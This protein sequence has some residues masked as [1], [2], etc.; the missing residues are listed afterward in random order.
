MALAIK[1]L[2][3]EVYAVRLP[4]ILLTVLFLWAV[5]SVFRLAANP[6]VGFWSAWLCAVGLYPVLLVAGAAGMDHNDVAYLAYSWAGLAVLL[7][8]ETNTRFYWWCVALAG[9]LISMAVL[10]KWAFGLFGL[11]V[12]GTHQLMHKP[13][14]R[15]VFTVVLVGVIAVLPHLAW[16]LY[17][18]AR[19]AT[20]HAIESAYNWTHIFT[21]IEGH[22][23]GLAFYLRTFPELYS[24]LILYA[25]PLLLVGALWVPKARPSVLGA[26]VAG[27]LG[28]YLFFSL[29]VQT[30]LAHY[31]AVAIP[32]VFGLVAI[33]VWHC[34]R[35]VGHLPSQALRAAAL[36]AAPVLLLG[37]CLKPHTWVHQASQL[38]SACA[39]QWRAATQH[40]TGQPTVLHG[41]EANTHPAVMFYTPC[42]AHDRVLTTPEVHYY[43]SRGFAV[44]LVDS[45]PHRP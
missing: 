1:L 41:L 40:L 16:S 26:L 36:A 39:T 38:P 43:Q 37:L 8:A 4:S 45:L 28:V 5:H 23:G 20:E 15:A 25:L 30:K 34:T 42:I 44:I 11:A 29:V 3:P 13:S 12:W 14:L 31:V 17:A 7:K 10:S 9:V 33:G 19:F 35:M 18:A 21:P 27:L 24:S 32:I 6:S 2:G 22:T